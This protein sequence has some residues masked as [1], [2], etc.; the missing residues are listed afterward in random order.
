MGQYKQ[1]GK[2]SFWRKEIGFFKKYERQHCVILVVTI[3]E[4]SVDVCN[5]NNQES[6]GDGCSTEPRADRFMILRIASGTCFL[7]QSVHAQIYF[8]CQDLGAESGLHHILATF[9]R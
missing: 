1:R 2:I 9:H 3:T 4:E 5:S 8:S 7:F 6:N